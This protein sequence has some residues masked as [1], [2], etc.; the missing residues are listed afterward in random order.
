MRGIDELF[1]GNK[2]TKG[3]ILTSIAARSISGTS[4]RRSW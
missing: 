3:T 1:V 2:L 4:A